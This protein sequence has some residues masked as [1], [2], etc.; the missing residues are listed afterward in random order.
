[1]AISYQPTQMF[2]TNGGF[3]SIFE[4]SSS[5]SNYKKTLTNSQS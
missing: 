3:L 4:A 1:M 5:E 2:I